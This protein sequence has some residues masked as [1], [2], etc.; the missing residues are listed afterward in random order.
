M[1]NDVYA[2]ALIRGRTWMAG[3]ANPDG[4][5]GYTIDR[6][7]AGEP[8][9]LAVAA[10]LPCPDWLSKC[11]GYARL[12]VPAAI[13]SVSPEISAPFVRYIIETEANQTPATD[14]DGMIPGWSW[15]V[16]TAAWVAPTAYAL[17]SLQRANAGKARVTQGMSMLRDR[18]SSDGG[19]NYGNPR[20]QGVDLAGQV[21]PTAWAVMAMSAGEETTRGFEF[22][23]QVLDA[24]STMGLALT[25]LARAKH[26]LDEGG[27]VAPLASRIGPTGVRGRIDLTALAVA[28]IAAFEED[29]HVFW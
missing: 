8:T 17:L 13:H 9:V 28:A 21:V 20:V 19:W 16:G 26:G 1:S 25:A 11:E 3:C 4:G 29:R 23:Q 10:G 22:L 24:H 7:S 2:K 15:V 5:Y 6:A 14:F 12:L 27:F 18:Q